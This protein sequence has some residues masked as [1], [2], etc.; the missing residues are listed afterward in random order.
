M[1]KLA[2]RNT[3][4]HCFSRPQGIPLSSRLGLS[5][6]LLS[7]SSILAITV[8]AFNTLIIALVSPCLLRSV[9]WRSLP[10]API[11]VYVPLR[12]RSLPA[13]FHASIS[14]HTHCPQDRG[15]CTKPSCPRLPTTMPHWP[16]KPPTVVRR[17]RSS[18]PYPC[19]SL[20]STSHCHRSSSSLSGWAFFDGPPTHLSHNRTCNR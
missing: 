12:D 20:P 6:H 11:E 1:V 8:C 15:L 13:R 3:R 2:H 5:S 10:V 7:T 17:P 4:I 9:S 16:G 14:L 18:S 19:T